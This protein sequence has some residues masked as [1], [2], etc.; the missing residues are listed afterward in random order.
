ML[1]YYRLYALLHAVPPPWGSHLSHPPYATTSCCVKKEDRQQRTLISNQCAPPHPDP[2][3][4]RTARHSITFPRRAARNPT[5]PGAAQPES[6]TQD[7]L[8]PRKQN[9]EPKTSSRRA[10][11]IQN[12]RPP[13]AAQ[14]ESR[15]QDLL[16]PRNQNPEPKTSRR[17]TRTQNVPDSSRSGLVVTAAACRYGQGR[18]WLTIT[19]CNFNLLR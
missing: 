12:P 15:T 6:R 11:R 16:A 19:S 7:V 10:T 2:S 3:S 17:A 5:L 8:A 13:R 14:P 9:P 4:H 18:L 1:Q